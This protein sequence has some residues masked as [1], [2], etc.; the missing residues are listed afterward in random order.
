M[1]DPEL[2]GNL[3]RMLTFASKTSEE[4]ANKI[5]S[6][7]SSSLQFMH[8]DEYVIKNMVGCSPESVNFLR[9]VAALMSRRIT[10]RVKPMKKYRA[11]VIEEYIKGLFFGLTVECLYALMFDDDGKFISSD[12]IGEGAVNA[13]SFVPR[14]LLDV[15]IKKKAKKV[16][17]AHNHPCGAVK[18]SSEDMS[19]TRI[20]KMLLEDAG[21]KVIAHYIVSG[22][23]VSDCMPLLLE[24]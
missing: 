15:A 22:F 9:L 17:I 7:Y 12:V 14:K 6:E 23:E 3:T 10:D 20:V 4:D 13:A 16:I 2:L 19:T 21:I 1:H 8:I 11:K 18:P 24:N 5:V